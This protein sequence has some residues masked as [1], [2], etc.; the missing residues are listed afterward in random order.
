MHAV[1][2]AGALVGRDSEMTRL[3]GLIKDLARGRGS[4]VLIE[5]EPGIGKSALVRA[6]V[7]E[8]PEA[9]CQVFWGA[10]DELGQELP[11]LPFLDALRVREPSA[12]P[13]RDT[14]VRLLRGEVAA[15]RGT[16]VPAVLAEQ[17]LA[18]VAE[19]CDIRPT[20]LVIDDLQWAD[21]ASI[22]LWG[23]LAKA[24]QQVPLLLAGM[25][26]PVPL[27]D[28][29]LA[30]RRMTGGASRLQLI[31]LT[32][33]AVADLV[34]MLAGGQPDGNLLRLADGAAGNPLYLTE[35]VAALARGSG[36]TVTE[37]GGAELV[38]G[39]APGSLSAAIADRLGFV[40]GPVRDVLRAAALLGTD[41]AVTD[42][43]IVLGRSVTDLIP[44]VD[45]AC[46]AGVLAES[47]HGLGF[48]HPLIR[49]ALY[50]DMPAPVRAAWHRDAGR[51]LA[52][53]G[54]PP[55]R[56]ARQM[57][58]AADGFGPGNGEPMDEWML[59]WLDH[60]ADL[61]IGQAP[62]VAAELLT[63]AFASSPAGSARH[64][65]LA[66]RLADALYRTGDAAAA[67]QVAIGALEYAAEPDLLEDLHWTL[68]QCRMRAG[69]DAESLATLD[70][71][72]AS[73]GI[74]ARYRTRLLVLAA[75]THSHLGEVDK[76]GRVATEA[77]G[78]ASEA[79]DNWAMGWALHVLTLVTSTQGRMTDA[80]PLFDRALTVTQAD[81][82]LT[83]LRLLLQINKAV[84]L[85]CL[86]QYEQAFAAAEQARQLADQ[87]GTAIR[88]AQA[89]GALAQ[90][91][92]ET[93][94]WDEALTE[95]EIVPE[96]LKE[97][98]AA[99]CDLGIAA[100]ISF[101]RGQTAEARGHLAAAVP[102]AKRIG[103]RPIGSLALARSLDYEEAGAQHEALAALTAAF[104]GNT[105]DLG[106]VE[107]L[108]VDAARLATEVADQGT[109][110]ALAGHAD[111]LAA[112]SEIPHRQAN[113]L[114][115][116]GLLDRDAPRLLAA[117][118][119]YQD[120]GRPLQR[121]KAL[122]AAAG[123]FVDADDKTQA[124]AAFTAAV[125]VYTSLGAA[126]DV[127]RLQAEFR[128]HGIRRGSH[129]KH[130]RAQSGWDSLTA[131]E[132]KIAAFVEEGLSNPEIA[133]RLLLSR[134]TV[135]THVSHILK[136]L[137]V[138]SRIDI[139]RESA[140]RTITPR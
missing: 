30:L 110:A 48:R 68:A 35:L 5:G 6:A 13:R 1:T 24:A 91:L 22:T 69:E 9:G 12:N 55:D 18:L 83:D 115:C 19:Q 11:L 3:T 120:A 75:R 72:L 4:S 97:P 90:L 139:A 101:H 61:L 28:D 82:A 140:L 133:A 95:V 26:R 58:R 54:A 105:E 64:G 16:D 106:E 73:P 50:D 65:W 131:T 33:D 8:A 123:H 59:G 31:E 43:A 41:F 32:G 130:R 107:D 86:D 76:A 88:L 84:T 103:S 87:V 47:G 102:H 2:P 53:A 42:L 93:G 15:D 23:R 116:R 29:V 108:L 136:K 21:Q 34:A 17:L 60:S 118:E 124:R 62:G 135:A 71:A 92:F 56:V 137:N 39:P 100:V 109:V 129:A 127:A 20:I 111:A 121:A 126:A 44:A 119:R 70:R 46:A 14:I 38:A 63:R 67:E 78:A 94:R 27:R 117:A 37:A 138:N 122:D 113:A 10:G 96:D 51:A 98:G 40:A 74:S 80:L 45:E 36:L 7:A 125:D 81:P 89:H 57:L 66:S 104:D 128:V 112:E 52:A 132:I 49:T 25:M 114:Y 134:R 77:L 99:C 85:K 79:G